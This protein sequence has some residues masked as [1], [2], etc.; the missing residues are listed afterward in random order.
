VTTAGEFRR[1]ASFEADRYGADAWVFVRELVQNSRDAGATHVELTTERLNGSERLV[2]RD[3]GCGMSFDHARR[4]LFTLY[5]SSKR[6]S[7]DDAGHFGIGFWSVLRFDPDI[8]VVRSAPVDGRSWEVRL[9]GDLEH[10]EVAQTSLERGTEIE[11]VRP[12]GADD[13]NEAVW[14]AVR[15]DAR[16]LRRRGAGDETLEV[17]VNSNRATTELDL[18]PPSL[19]FSRPGLR[20]AVALGEVPQVDLLAHGLRVRTAAT[21]DELLADPVTHRRRRAPTLPDGLV[22]QVVIDSR[23]L[24][25]LMAR[26]DARSDRELHRL[27]SLGTRGLR[28]LVRSELDREAGLGRL[29]RAAMRVRE[30]LASRWPLRC[31]AGLAVAGSVA[32]GIARWTNLGLQSTRPGAAEPPGLAA[33]VDRRPEAALAGDLAERYQGPVSEAISRRPGRVALR[34]RPVT[35]NPMLA[36]FRVDAVDDGGRSLGTAEREPGVYDGVE[37]CSGCIELELDVVAGPG[38]VRLPLPTGHRLDPAS[39]YLDGRT[40]VL[41]AA[42][43]G[44]PLLVLAEE[45][46][47][48]IQYRTGPSAD[49]DDWA[50]GV[51]PSLPPEASAFAES[52]RTLDADEAATLAG[53]WVRAH[54]VYDASQG[55]AARHRSADVSRLGFFERCLAVGAGD[56]D[57]QSTLAVAILDHAG[58]PARLAVGWVGSGGCALPGLHAWVEFR[59]VGRIWH[60]VDVS[61]EPRD[62]L[63]NSQAATPS[64]AAAEETGAATRQS[65]LGRRTGRPPAAVGVAFWIG[66][67]TLVSTAAI[68][69]HGSRFRHRHHP[70]DRG[71]LARLVRGALTRPE[72]YAE[73][74]AL[75]ERRIVPVHGGQPISLR[76]ARRLAERNLLAVASSARELARPA[77]AA[78]CGVVDGDRPEGEAAASVLGAVDLDR[79]QRLLARSRRPQLVCRLERAAAETGACWQVLLVTG[80]TGDVA[81]LDG[82]LVGRRR[83]QPVIAVDEEGATWRAASELVRS[84]P[85]VAA[86]LLAEAVLDALDWPAWRRRQIL[87][88]LAVDAV[89][90]LAEAH[91]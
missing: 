40:P 64:A 85:A 13:L 42:A 80:S 88:R 45:Y 38:V 6:D 69:L 57:V 90:E 51:W 9:S 32:L 65:M 77:T 68:A 20:G 17:L 39:L 12:A 86:L 16:Y 73:V 60:A 66:L 61:V 52:L 3:D 50:S 18:P 89:A 56:C 4:Y 81:V 22:P 62:R 35:A 79:W 21:L 59:G 84:C 87:E 82:R 71:D 15:Q 74:P 72:A 19:G 8:V 43:D 27:V 78:G 91:R 1:R 31:L 49:R 36:V 24:Q 5:A 7:D 58:F 55:T 67:V 46:R 37:C 54:V 23:R 14:R 26:G 75:F 29:G 25:V 28:R 53:D 11:L 30:A 34:Y 44:G 47:G 2:C 10:V 48:R 63:T 83:Q 33:A 70:G 76:R 41:Q